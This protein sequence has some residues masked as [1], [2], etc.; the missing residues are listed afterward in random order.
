MSRA[1][2]L[3]TGALDAG[4]GCYLQLLLVGES[5]LVTQRLLSRQPDLAVGVDLD[6]LDQHLVA[7]GEHVADGADARLRDLRD[8]QETF[9]SLHD[10]DEG[11]ELLDAL[12]LAEIDA[13][14]LRLAT[15]VLDDVHRHLRLLA[16]RR[17]H[18]HL[19]IVLDVDLGAGLLLDAA[20]D[21]AAWA[22]DL[23]DL[24]GSD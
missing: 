2:L 12:D 11:A 6:R 17:E 13:V 23:P 10:L 8:V 15:D 21:L 22:D 4:R 14:Q 5:G 20:D 7:L 24:F 9:G 3:S 18:G 16:G 1:P 19:A